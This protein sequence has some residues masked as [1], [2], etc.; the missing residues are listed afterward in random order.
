M[1]QEQDTLTFEQ[2]Y[3]SN[4]SVLRGYVAAGFTHAR[5]GGLARGDL[6]DIVAE[7]MER[8]YLRWNEI[9]APRSYMFIVARH[10]AMDIMRSEMRRGNRVE[11]LDGTLD[12]LLAL[13]ESERDDPVGSAISEEVLATAVSTMSMSEKQVFLR[14]VAGSNHRAIADD[15]GLTISAVKSRFARARAK[16][17]RS[18]SQAG[19]LDETATRVSMKTTAGEIAELMH[20]LQQTAEHTQ[21]RTLV[22]RDPAAH[23]ALDDTDGVIELLHQLQKI[24]AHDQVQTLAERAV[25]RIALDNPHTVTAMLHWLQEV[26]AH[27]QLSTLVKRDPARHVALD[28]TEGVIELIYQLRD[29]GA[30]DQMQALL[31]RAIENLGVTWGGTEGFLDG[32]IRLLEQALDKH[33]QVLGHDHPDTLATRINL[34]QAYLRSGRHTEAIELLE[35]TLADY[36]QI[37]GHDDLATLAASSSLA[38]GYQLTGRTDEAIAL[39][40]QVLADYEQILGHDDPRT[41]TAVT[42]LEVAYQAHINKVS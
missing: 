33:A 18:L 19:M 9:S 4:V 8:M 28:D 22:E 2:F 25:V 23:V 5:F 29:V 26:G 1:P 35:R 14:R 20:R 27:T 17:V 42:N 13:I 41:Q 10:V 36:E 21:L 11:S 34:G 7:T 30:H 38:G 12:D 31:D 6:D 37:L 32:A 39:F 15:L 24:G 16:A 40:E 3:R